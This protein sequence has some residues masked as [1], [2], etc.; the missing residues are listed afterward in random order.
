MNNVSQILA[1]RRMTGTPAE[2]AALKR[3][4]AKQI[5]GKIEKDKSQEFT[6]YIDDCFIAVCE[7]LRVFDMARDW[8]TKKDLDKLE[9]AQNII[10]RFVAR[11][12]SD[13]ANG[14][15]REYNDRP[16]ESVPD[17]SVT[18]TNNGQMS[19]SKDGRVNVNPQFKYLII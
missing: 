13:T 11:I 3:D 5:A 16:I 1:L 19:V 10:R 7:E 4:Q 12:K 8:A 15:A 14:R 6:K 2:W 17:I 9:I 18:G